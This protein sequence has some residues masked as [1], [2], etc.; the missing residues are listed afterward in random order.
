M[1]FPDSSLMDM[2]RRKP[3]TLVQFSSVSG[4]GVIK[5]EKYGEAFTSLIKKHFSESG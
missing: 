2:C 3:V 5:L 4:V 1:V